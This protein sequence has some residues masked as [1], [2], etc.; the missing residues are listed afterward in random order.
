M[1]C[2]YCTS[3]IADE[4]L[5]C[6]HCAHDLYLLKPLQAKITALEKDIA[7]LRSKLAAGAESAAGPLPAAQPGDAEPARPL[8]GIAL[9]CLAPLAALLV[10]HG[11]IAIIYD[12]DTLYLRLVSLL[13]PL[14]FGFLAMNRGVR[15]LGIW[16]AAGFSMAI[17]AVLG[18]S[19]LTHWVD[20]TPILPND[21]REWREFL[22]Y[23][24]SIGLSYL[25][26]ML[27][28]R[29]VR[30]RRQA[31]PAVRNV[32]GAM[33]RIA[34]LLSA[35]NASAEQINAL[36]EKLNHIG[37]AA[38]A[39]ATTAASAYAGLKGFLGGS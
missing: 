14:P 32:K 34:K 37:S 38:T 10:A 36:T 19:G 8:A 5:A 15:R 1:K 4:A 28:G 18:M 25:T 39:A 7:D 20:A 21:L 13:I 2:P 24:A 31:V 17:L 29:I 26:G 23:A 33:E 16:S 6:P 9:Y 30:R 11:L 12:L 22:E 27:L 35:G 3:E